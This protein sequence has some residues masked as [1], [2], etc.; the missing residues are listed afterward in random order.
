MQIAAG[1]K[2]ATGIP[3]PDVN[4]IVA[5]D[6][7]SFILLSF[8]KNGFVF[9][10]MLEA[11]ILMVQLFYALWDSVR[12]FSVH[13]SVCG[14]LRVAP[15]AR[16]WGP[17][18]RMVYAVRTQHLPAKHIHFFNVGRSDRENSACSQT[19]RVTAFR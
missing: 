17:G 14:K 12:C 7:P 2:H 4:Q 16:P 5:S 8:R 6:M 15:R 9:E 18:T 1:F 3:L 19:S 11:A 10:K 13:S